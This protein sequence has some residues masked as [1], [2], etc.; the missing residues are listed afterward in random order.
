MSYLKTFTIPNCDELR[1]RYFSEGE[2]LTPAAEK[3]ITAEKDIAEVLALLATLPESG[4][5]KMSM[6]PV[7]ILQIDFFYQ[8]EN[9]GSI[10]FFNGLLKLLNN[11]FALAQQDEEKA[12]YALL[13]AALEH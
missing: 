7:P 11:A 6:A 8:Q 13:M 3:T 1:I 9:I 4:D 5:I 10:E 2:Y 12:L